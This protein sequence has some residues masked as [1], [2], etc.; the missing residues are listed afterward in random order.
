MPGNIIYNTDKPLSKPQV[1]SAS[2]SLLLTLSLPLSLS[3][4]SM[5]LHVNVCVADQDSVIEVSTIS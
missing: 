5:I 2:L 3:F 1:D 4:S